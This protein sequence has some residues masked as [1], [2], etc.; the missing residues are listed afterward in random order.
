M[1][2]FTTMALL[3]SGA[4]ASFENTIGV[5]LGI[6]PDSMISYDKIYLGYA[7]NYDPQV[8]MSHLNGETGQ[9][10]ATYNV[11]SQLKSSNVDSGSYDGNDQYNVDDIISSGAVLIASLMP[12]IDWDEVTP[13][14]CE[15]VASYFENTFTSQG[16][17][18]WLRYAHEM[19]YYVTS[20]SGPK[21]PGGANYDA[22][23]TSWNNMY[24]AVKNN[25]KI[26]MYWSP[27]QASSSSLQPWFPSPSTIDIVGIDVYPR[28]GVQTFAEAYGDFYNAFA[29]PNNLPFAIG[30]TGIQEGSDGTV[31]LSVRQQWL[32]NIINPS[33][34]LGDYPLYFSATWFEYGPPVN[35]ITYYIVYG[36]SKSE[37]DDTIA[38]TR[39]GSA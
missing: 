38:N 1:K 15:S 7:P 14:L 10:G 31:S 20:E 24:N 39:A 18:I 11:Y 27:N 22:Y 9:K 13:G 30:E 29:S 5:N 32:K 19:N 4:M 16:V 6:K 23:K 26:H 12:E 3:A 35:D 37:V 34:G 33:E 25:D 36:L 28:D 21:Y 8:T 17:T 2:S